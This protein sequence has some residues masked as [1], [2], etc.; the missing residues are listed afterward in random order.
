MGCLLC[1]HN[2]MKHLPLATVQHTILARRTCSVL[3][4]S[5]PH[6]FM[7]HDYAP[8]YGDAAKILQSVPIPT[9]QN[10]SKPQVFTASVSTV[11]VIPADPSYFSRAVQFISTLHASTAWECQDQLD[12]DLQE[13]VDDQVQKRLYILLTRSPG[14]LQGGKM[15]SSSWLRVQLKARTYTQPPPPPLPVSSGEMGPL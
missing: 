8:Y 13:D 10:L 7:L 6:A 9:H 3:Q 4:G 11:T 15:C 14:G 5:R 12:Y 1:S 2:C